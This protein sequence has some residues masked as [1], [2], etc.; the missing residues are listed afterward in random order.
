MTAIFCL[1]EIPTNKQ[2]F[3]S[4][5]VLVFFLQIQRVIYLVLTFFA[6]K[7]QFVFQKVLLCQLKN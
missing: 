1:F 2:F 5:C 6:C 4:L 7:M 3:N